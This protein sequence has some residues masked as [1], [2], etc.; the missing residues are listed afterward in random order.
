MKKYLA[1]V[2]SAA[3][4]V[5]LVGCGSSTSAT[6]SATASADSEYMSNIAVND[7]K[8]DDTKNI[9]EASSQQLQTMDYVV[10]A[11]AEDHEYN[12]NFVDGLL[13]NDKYGNLAECLATGYSVSDDGLTY[14]FYLRE[15]VQWVTNSGEEYAEVTADDFVTG[16]RHGAEFDSGTAWL[17]DGVIKGYSE[18]RTNADWSDEAWDAVGVKAVDDYTVEYTLEQPTPYF[19]AMT[20]YA[21][22]YPINREFL[23]TMG[24]GCA[25]GSPDT[26]ACSFGTTEPDSI[27]YNGGFILESYDTKSSIV[28]TKNDAYWDADNIKIDSVTRIYDDGSDPYSQI[29]NFEQGVYYAAPIDASWENFDE[30]MEKYDGYT[31]ES[32]PNNSCFGIVF[33][34]NRQSFE[35][36]NYAD[37]ET[38]RENTHNAILNE[39]FRKALRAAWDRQ[40][41]LE[42]S[43]PSDLA[44]SML[45]NINDDPEIVRTSDGTTYGELVEQAYTERTGETVDLSDGQNPWD[46]STVA[47]YIAAAE[48]DGITFPVHLDM[49]VM[50]S[51]KRL[52]DQ[53]QSMKN[54]VEENSDGN[55]II[56][57]I[58]CDDDTIKNIAYYNTDPATADY[59]IST[60]TGWSPDYP[61]PKTFVDI[62]SP[63]TGYYMTACGLTNS[64]DETYG[65]DDDIKEQ[66]GMMEYQE[67]Y[68]A[69]D[70]IYDDLDARYAAFA[71]CDAE[72]IDYA[73]YIPGQ[74]QSRTVR[75]THVVP[76]SRVYS[77]TGLTE[78]KYK[79]LEVQEDV[80]TAADYETAY[81]DFQTGG[82][83]A[84]LV[85]EK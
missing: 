8:L 1:G 81:E 20:T 84:D 30:Y 71:K 3:M 57:L 14:D 47:D 54:S 82:T 7:I 35:Q 75:V 45:R 79:G 56:E 51:S 25:L 44:L 60:F 74:M 34:F 68:E 29:R 76:F 85:V 62:Y 23:E 77:K 80:V 18:Y 64:N 39:N 67:L 21:V 53:A 38:M 48:E 50:S 63:V 58:M 6:T 22:L 70:A 24:D 66:I 37:D 33:N 11:L 42:V 72:M 69:A 83:A 28:M 9:V 19:P 15:G 49:L 78:Y 46:P 41:Y 36:T 27:L 13:E 59:D 61:D 17:L 52:T 40:A 32:L 73:F 26:G 31:T 10:T 12:A 43:A 55:I 65:S 16:L 4:A 2:C 5:A